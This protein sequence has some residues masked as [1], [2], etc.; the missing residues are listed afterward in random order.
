MDNC[1]ITAYCCHNSLAEGVDPQKKPARVPEYL[2]LIELP[3]SGKIDMLY[4]LK[5]F[6]SGADGVM[7]VGCPE[8]DCHY[9]EGNLR[10]RKRVDITRDLLE[11]IGLE[12]ERL[13]MFNF[14][15][16]TGDF[17][18]ICRKMRQQIEALGR[19]PINKGGKSA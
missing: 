13:E 17:G 10:A 18:Q 11:Q 16:A 7:V 15:A 3:C 2:E 8:G 12:P 19:S 14:K 1:K 4:L 6:E 9:L 5:A